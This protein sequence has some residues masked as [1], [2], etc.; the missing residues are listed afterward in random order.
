VD[1][2]RLVTIL[3]ANFLRI[4]APNVRL[5]T[6]VRQLKSVV[7]QASRTFLSNQQF[8]E[9]VSRTRRMRRLRCKSLNNAE[10]SMSLPAGMGFQ[11]VLDT[12]DTSA[13]TQRPEAVLCDVH[14]KALVSSSGN[15][16]CQRALLFQAAS[17]DP[18]NKVSNQSGLKKMIPNN[19]TS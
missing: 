8:P 9:Y 16:P 4:L 18:W 5:F 17:A 1:E 11:A 13:G 15:T 14:A 12:E 19:L 7:A 2:L 6:R 10:D 3:R